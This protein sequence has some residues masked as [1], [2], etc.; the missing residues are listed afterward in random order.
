MCFPPMLWV[1]TP[2][3]GK[4]DRA[5]SLLSC[6]LTALVPEK[7]RDQTGSHHEAA[8]LTQCCLGGSESL[9]GEG[10]VLESTRSMRPGSQL[11]SIFLSDLGQV[12]SCHSLSLPQTSELPSESLPMEGK[13]ELAV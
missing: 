11:N 4:Q 8:M 5:F 10:E 2:L 7:A 9:R 6:Q 3:L 1:I 12:T 13:T